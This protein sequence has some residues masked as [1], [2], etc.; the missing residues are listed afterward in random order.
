M[1]IYQGQVGVGPSLCQGYYHKLLAWT[2]GHA[3]G[4]GDMQII[5]ALDCEIIC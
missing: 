2:N 4:A 1:V 5:Q 3:N